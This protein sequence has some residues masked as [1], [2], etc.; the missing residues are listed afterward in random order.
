[1]FRLPSL[2]PYPY[3]AAI[4][5]LAV[6]WTHGWYLGTSSEKERSQEAVLQAKIEAQKVADEHNREN[7]R[8]VD[9]A[10]AQADSLSAN[11]RGAVV[12]HV[13]RLRDLDPGTCENRTDSVVGADEQSSSANPNGGSAGQRD[14]RIEAYQEA[15]AELSAT[16]LKCSQLLEVYAEALR[17]SK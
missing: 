17:D 6:V 1:M 14:F 13:N 11:R 3:V 9:R 10:R 8:L 16:G 5:A 7:R 2:N 12:D 15:I 4:L